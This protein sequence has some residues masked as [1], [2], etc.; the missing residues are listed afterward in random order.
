MAPMASQATPN[1]TFLLQFAST[2]A[3]LLPLLT[4]PLPD[5]SASLAGTLLYTKGSDQSSSLVPIGILQA[6]G[7]FPNDRNVFVLHKPR[8]SHLTSFRREDSH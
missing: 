3:A 5:P 1:L 6:L 2:S 7:I 8:G 4:C